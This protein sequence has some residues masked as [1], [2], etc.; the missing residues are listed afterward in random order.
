MELSDMAPVK[1]RLRGVSHQ[2]AFF[3]ALVAGRRS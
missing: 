2:W 1:P 3:V